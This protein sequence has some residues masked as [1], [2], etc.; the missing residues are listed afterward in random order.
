[1]TW[2]YAPTVVWESADD[3][4]YVTTPDVGDILLLQGSAFL[5]WIELP[6][7]SSDELIDTLAELVHLKAAD[8]ADDVRGFMTKLADQGLIEEGSDG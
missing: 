2:R 7:R 1:M 6:G 4:A 5:V 8:I 3:I